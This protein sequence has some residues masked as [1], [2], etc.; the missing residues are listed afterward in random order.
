MIPFGIH[1]KQS[2]NPGANVHLLLSVTAICWLAAKITGWKVWVTERTF[3]VIAPFDFLNNIP[4]K[5]HWL[6]FLCSVALLLL[7][8]IKPA[9][10]IFQYSLFFS[11]LCSCILDQNR[12]Q[13]W[14]YLYLFILFIFI[15]NKKN[16]ATIIT[17]FTIILATIYMYSGLHK[18]NDN[19][20]TSMW[21]G[22][23][24]KRFF[25]IPA[26]LYHVKLIHYSGYLLP[27]IESLAG[28]GL[29]FSK[30]K[31]VSAIILVAMHIFILLL[32]GPLGLHYNKIVWPW[33]IAMIIYLYFLFIKKDTAPS[34]NI[35]LLNKS[36]K[37]ILLCWTILPALNFIGLWDNYLSWCIY[38]Y[39]LPLMAIC[40]KD[41]ATATQFHSYLNKKDSLNICDS[42]ALLNIQNWA[43]KEMNV[44][45]YPEER[46][47]KKIEE[48]W[49]KS[50]PLS[51][52]SFVI[53]YFPFKGV[54]QTP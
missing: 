53:Y 2:A 54:L 50:F 1:K 8:V 27:A 32:I 4:S 31:K 13:P 49:K 48:H 23:I 36:N 46:V 17:C 35:A 5:L 12:W 51:N 7:L 14:E 41:S 22:T 38:S 3:P 20:L 15:V 26:W 43:L 33:N 16:A 44:P 24:L 19:F 30:T 25:K 39:N 29:L 18:F 52:V 10:K 11:E 28:L 42:N 6:F 34:Q 47:Y 45:A 37:I 21:D 9:N 40:I